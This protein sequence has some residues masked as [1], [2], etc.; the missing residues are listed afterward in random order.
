MSSAL[1]SLVLFLSAA[2][3]LKYVAAVLSGPA[4]DETD[5]EGDRMSATGSTM[6]SWASTALDVIADLMVGYA[7]GAAPS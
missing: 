3:G 5:S 6:K 7:G 4:N 1:P 2:V